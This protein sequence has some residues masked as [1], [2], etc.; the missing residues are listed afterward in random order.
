MTNSVP[1][2]TQR[3]IRGSM[4]FSAIVDIDGVHNPKTGGFHVVDD[5]VNA[6]HRSIFVR[7]GTYPFAHIS[8]SNVY[9]QGESMGH[10]VFDGEDIDHAIHVTGARVHLCNLM[11]KTTPGG[12]TGYDGIYANG[13]SFSVYERIL[14]TSSDNVGINVVAGSDF[15]HIINSQIYSSIDSYKILI[16][17][18]Y[19]KV[20]GCYIANAGLYGIEVTGTNARITNNAFNA[21]TTYAIRLNTNGDNAIVGHNRFIST[22][23]TNSSGTGTVADN[24]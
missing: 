19:V 18:S 4:T 1:W 13:G 14:C 17:A 12:G 16:A 8:K 2:P 15:D 24:E 9:V 5:A 11:G 7:D 6:D 21:N 23:L 20:E 22:T 3:A 10:T